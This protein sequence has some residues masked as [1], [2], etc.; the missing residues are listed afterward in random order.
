MFESLKD[1]LKAYNE[2]VRHRYYNYWHVV[3]LLVLYEVLIFFSATEH[4]AVFNGVD[5]WFLFFYLYFPLHSL[6]ISILIL[7]LVGWKIWLDHSGTKDRAENQ[8]DKKKKKEDKAYKAKDK[9]KKKLNRIHLAAIPLEGFV[10]GGLLYAFLPFIA[11]AFTL[12]LTEDPVIPYP[13]DRQKLVSDFQSNPFQNIALSLGA[14]FYEEVIFRVVLV[15]LLASFM[16]SRLSGKKKP[17]KKGEGVNYVEQFLSF[18][19]GQSMVKS[20]GLGKDYKLIATVVILSALIFSVTHYIASA[21]DVFTPYSFVFRIL[22]G[23]FMNILIF[24]RKFAVT[25]WT[26]AFYDMLYF[27]FA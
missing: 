10:Y 27:I 6:P 23:L 2:D 13:F 24:S 9:E 1:F 8:Q 21:G 18:S 12:V 3:I 26:H 17:K 7:L 11:Y 22:F 16:V 25:A 14:G 5:V 20:K 4:V 19:M 15:G